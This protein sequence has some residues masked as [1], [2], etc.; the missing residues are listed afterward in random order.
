MTI[1]L[2]LAI[3]LAQ[4]VGCYFFLR[5]CEPSAIDGDEPT[6]RRVAARAAALMFF[7]WPFGYLVIPFMGV[8]FLAR[9]FANGGD[10]EQ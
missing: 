7:A 6:S 8:C 2:C 9:E 3:S 1:F 5:L 4:A 10:G